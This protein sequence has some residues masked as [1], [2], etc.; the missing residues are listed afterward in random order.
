MKV[1]FKFNNG[2]EVQDRISGLTGIIDCA[3]LW[4]NGCKRY[5][6]QPK[7]KEG[8]TERPESIWIDEE[9]IVKL[10]D[11]IQ[12][13]NYR[14]TGE[15]GYGSEST[16]QILSSGTKWEFV[17]RPQTPIS[18]GEIQLNILPTANGWTTP[19]SGIVSVTKGCILSA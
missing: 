13:L 5:S 17:F 15:T 18:N 1:E 6:V 8:D 19:T 7:M 2:E 9:T 11:G 12:S 16:Y 3:A 10:S 4:I 14:L